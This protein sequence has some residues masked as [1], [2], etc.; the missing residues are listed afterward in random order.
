MS[1]M[2][3]SETICSL[4]DRLQHSKT[5]KD[6]FVNGFKKLYLRIPRPYRDHPVDQGTEIV[7][8]ELILQML[9]ELVSALKSKK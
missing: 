8:T 1:E 9:R 3:R 7:K 2:T 6:D 5:D 4:F